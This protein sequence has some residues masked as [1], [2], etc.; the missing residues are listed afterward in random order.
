MRV[1]L[2]PAYI[3]HSRPFRDTSV[4]IECFTRDFGRL[5]LLAKGGRSA[6]SALRSV[7]QPFVPVLVS[8][9]GKSEL[10]TLTGAEIEHYQARLQG[11]RLFSGL[12][13]NE[14]LLRLLPVQDAHPEILDLYRVT[15][16][17]LSIISVELE[18]ILR[19]FEFSLLDSLG[20][21]VDF[22]CDHQGL[23]LR[24][25]GYYRYWTEQG[26]VLTQADDPMS[27]HGGSLLAIGRGDFSDATYLRVAKQLSRIALLPH[28]GNK[29]LQSRA[30]FRSQ[31]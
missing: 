16:E 20:Y 9:Q 14:V 24:I 31:V 17:G 12:Y 15:L 1:E 28:L 29:P 23:P 25:D 10:K 4:I 22:F 21:G 3:L 18:P 11:V 19:Q 30:L 2:Q 6:K 5:S 27:F 26:F 7:L 8:W 13:I